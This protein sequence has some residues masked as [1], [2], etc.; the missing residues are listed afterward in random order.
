LTK[1][2]D[3]IL[4]NVLRHLKPLDIVAVRQTS[5]RLREPTMNKA[6]WMH[7]LRV[8]IADN[9]VYPPTFPIAQMSVTELEHAASC[10]QMFTRILLRKRTSTLSPIPSPEPV[11]RRAVCIKNHGDSDVHATSMR[12]IAG[13]RFLVVETTASVFVMDLG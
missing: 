3:D 4:M 8:V 6:V 7:A 12:L 11:H 1:L 13:G 2:P 10:P 5:R 9:N